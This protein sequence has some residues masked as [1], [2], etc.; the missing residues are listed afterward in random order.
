MRYQ[1]PNGKIVDIP[2]ELYLTLDDA[3]FENIAYQYCYDGGDYSVIKQKKEK[4][5]HMQFYDDDEND[6][7]IDIKNISEEDIDMKN[8]RYTEEDEKEEDD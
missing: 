6:I 3:E 7:N 1:L 2:L 8:N 5:I 4:K